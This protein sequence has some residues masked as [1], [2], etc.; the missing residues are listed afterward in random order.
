[1]P[2]KNAAMPNATL[3]R[4]SQCPPPPPASIAPAMVGPAA[5]AMA[6]TMAF[7]A[8]PR[9]NT[10]RGY[11]R[12]VRAMFTPMT[13]AAPTPCRARAATI[14]ANPFEAAHRAEAA[15]KITTPT[16]NDRR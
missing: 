13:Q 6:I 10:L 11:I 3:I 12:R 9:P 1:M 14:I 4:N 7:S 16:R 15:V 2:R 8:S 5:V